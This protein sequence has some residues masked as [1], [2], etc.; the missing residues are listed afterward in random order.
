MG[1]LGMKTCF[2][3]ASLHEASDCRSKPS[4]PTEIKIKW[5]GITI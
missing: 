1:P 4:S 2:E 5:A 3:I